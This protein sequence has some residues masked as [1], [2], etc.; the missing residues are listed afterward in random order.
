MTAYALAHLYPQ[1]TVHDDVFVYMER[2]QATL[3]PFG[4]RFLVHGSV[5]EVME[6][7]L[8]GAYVL[9]EFPD[10]DKARDW[11]RSD[12]YQAILPMR[13]DNMAGTAVLLHGVAEDYDPAETGALM[14]AAQAG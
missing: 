1:P 8:D 10:I 14:R 3:D 6:G 5:P 2:I 7:P 12:A 13:T 4:G 9:I 11:Y